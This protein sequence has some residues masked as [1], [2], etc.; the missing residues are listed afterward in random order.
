M[1]NSD[2]KGFL[3]ISVETMGGFYLDASG[4]NFFASA[5]R[6]GWRSDSGARLDEAIAESRPSE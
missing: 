2:R 4:S 6:S 3:I 1:I 5:L